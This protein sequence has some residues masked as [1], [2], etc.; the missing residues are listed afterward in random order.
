MYLKADKVN[1][2]PCPFWCLLLHPRTPFFI[3]CHFNLRSMTNMD[4]FSICSCYFNTHKVMK[5]NCCLWA[6]L[7]GWL[8]TKLHMHKHS[9][10]FCVFMCFTVQ[11]KAKVNYTELWHVNSLWSSC[12]NHQGCCYTM[13]LFSLMED[14]FPVLKLCVCVCARFHRILENILMPHS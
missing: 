3:S 13:P 2:H 9:W 14:S 6:C 8:I 5:D 7:N 11:M 1:V 10:L 4:H 12:K